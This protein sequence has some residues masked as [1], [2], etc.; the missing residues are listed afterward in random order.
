MRAAPRVLVVLCLAHADTTL[1]EDAEGPWP[2][3]EDGCPSSEISCKDLV[4]VPACHLRFDHVWDMPPG[5]MTG[6]DIKD[7]CPNACSP[8]F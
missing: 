4:E 6:K 2:C 8:V 5:G 7:S 1:G 3:I